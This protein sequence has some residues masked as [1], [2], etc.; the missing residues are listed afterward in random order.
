MLSSSFIKDSGSPHLIAPII[1]FKVVEGEMVPLTPLP[2]KFINLILA[3]TG[4]FNC[5][6]DIKQHIE[7]DMFPNSDGKFCT[8]TEIYL[9]SLRQKFH[10]FD[11]DIY[12]VEDFKKRDSQE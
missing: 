3:Y 10:S 1:S 6:E 9:C 5:Y 7:V 4:I 2:E 11:C 8:G 12:Y